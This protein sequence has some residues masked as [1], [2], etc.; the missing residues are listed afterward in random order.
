MLSGLVVVLLIIEP[1]LI[2]GLWMLIQTVGLSLATVVLTPFYV[3]LWILYTYWQFILPLLIILAY[4][5]L[6]LVKAPN[7]DNET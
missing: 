3:S 1:S 6:R 4:V 2:P 5:W 7:R